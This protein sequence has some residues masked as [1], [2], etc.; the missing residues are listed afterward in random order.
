V[1]RRPKSRLGLVL[2]GAIAAS[3][4][5]PLAVQQPAV[6]QSA[7][8][9]N[10][11][12]V[13]LDSAARDSEFVPD[14]EATLLA[15]LNEARREHHLPALVMS[16]HLRQAARLHSRDMAARGYLGHGTPGGA[17]FVERI[18]AFVR[19][20]ALVGENVVAAETPEQANSAFVSSR[21]HLE[22]ML[23]PSFHVVGIGVATAGR[24]GLMVTEDFAQ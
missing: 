10:A 11:V 17:S 24:I 19:P 2:A 20:G 18:S 1:G 14:A 6:S 13:P 12:V 22:N 15:L 21:G 9:L 7:S 23:N 8:S 16:P 3:L 5:L 4:I